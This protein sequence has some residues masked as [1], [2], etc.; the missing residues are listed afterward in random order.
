V[1]CSVQCGWAAAQS[2]RLPASALHVHTYVWLSALLPLSIL[3]AAAAAAAALGHPPGKPA[4]AGVL[5][6]CKLLASLTH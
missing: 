6:A 3:A 2:Q 1:V 4:E 5:Q